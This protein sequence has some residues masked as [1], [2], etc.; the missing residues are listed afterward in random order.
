MV[1]RHQ[2][3]L[4]DQQRE[5]RQHRRP[6]DMHPKGRRDRVDET[7]QREL[8]ETEDDEDR[9]A[10]RH[11][12]PEKLGA[13]GAPCRSSHASSPCPTRRENSV[14]SEEHTYEL[15]S[16]MRISYAVFCLKKKHT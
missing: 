7:P 5:P 10:D 15:Q 4:R 2:R 3:R 12:V 11:A 1:A 9:E 6:V 14:R 13:R 16:L 8:Q